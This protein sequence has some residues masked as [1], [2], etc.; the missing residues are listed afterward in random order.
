MA[1]DAVELAVAQHAQQ[2]RLQVERHVADLVEEQRAAVGLLEAAAARRLRAGEGA[3]LVAEQF[4][5]EQVLG[6]RRGVDRDERAL[7]ARGLCSCSAR[8]TSSLPVPLS[9]VISTVTWLWLSRPM[10]RNTSCIAG[11]WPSI[12]GACTGAVVGHLL[13]QAFVDRAP[14]QLDRDVDVEGL[15]QVLEGAALERRHRAVEVGE[16]GHDD[17]RQPGVALLDLGQ[18][19]DAAAAGHADVADQH[20][21]R[22]VASSARDHLARVGEACAPL[23]CSR[24]SAFSSTKRMD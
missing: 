15:G 12:S 5:F 21:R 7:A 3:A 17:H 20:L 11:A 13:A 22:V 2:P 24:A 19:V 9:P 23:N 6:D 10:A 18:Q 4:A 14:D 1:A 16:R 8:A